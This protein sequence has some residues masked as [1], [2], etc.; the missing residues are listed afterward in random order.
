MKGYISYSDL[1][2]GTLN[3][4]D[5]YVL[6]SAIEAEAQYNQEMIQK[7]KRERALNKRK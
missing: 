4:Y 3:L 1:K 6:N 2:N 7:V 5:I